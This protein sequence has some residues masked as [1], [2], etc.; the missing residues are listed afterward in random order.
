MKSD[1]VI[2]DEPGEYRMTARYSEDGSFSVFG[3]T[4]RPVTLTVRVEDIWSRM[5]EHHR[6]NLYVA[7]VRRDGDDVP[8]HIL[9]G[10]APD[11]RIFL[12][13]EKT[14]RIDFK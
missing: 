11:A 5:P 14:F 7:E 4:A 13:F 2:R 3:K 12:D 8:L 1:L 10:V 9:E 6:K